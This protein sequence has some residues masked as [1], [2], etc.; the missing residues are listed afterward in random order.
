MFKVNDVVFYGVHGVCVIEEI[1]EKKL[2]G[3]V[4]KYYTLKPVCSN[5]SKVFVPVDREDKTVALR[6]VIAGEEINEIIS[7]LKNAESIWI[8]NDA[9][10]K[11][12]FTEIIKHGTKKEIASPIK[13]VYEQRDKLASKKKKMHAADERA[14]TEAEKILYDEFAYVLGIG[15]EEVT[16]FIADTLG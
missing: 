3:S 13:T 11:P 16:Q 5:K 2:F 1:S 6:R 14:F 8:P 15:R 9:E 12:H 10:R 4:G 7:E